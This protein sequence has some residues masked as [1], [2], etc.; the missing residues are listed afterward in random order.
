M[1][2][3]NKKNEMQDTEERASEVQEDKNRTSEVQDASTEG[4]RDL[5]GTNDKPESNNQSDKRRKVILNFHMEFKPKKKH[6]LAVSIL[7]LILVIA[8]VVSFFVNKKEEIT[9]GELINLIKNGGISKIETTLDSNIVNVV[10]L[11][12][13]EKYASLS[14]AAAL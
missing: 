4:R 9:Y 8:F 3:E 11:D 14:Q 2:D 5:D 1:P 7:V 13:K 12:E 10:G 6:V